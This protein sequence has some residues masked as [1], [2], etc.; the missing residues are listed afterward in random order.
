[1][2]NPPDFD[3]LAR[4]AHG[5]ATR[6]AALKVLGL[7]A[8]VGAPM[9]GAV[10]TAGAASAQTASD[11]KAVVCVY[12]NGGNDQSNTVV[13]RSGS[14]YSSYASARGGLAIPANQLIALSPQ[15]WNGPE[16]GL[17]PSLPG[18]ATLFNQGRAAVIANVGPLSQPMTLAEYRSGAKS[19]PSQLFSH[20]DQL[21]AW[22]TGLPDRASRTGW[23]GRIGDVVGPGFNGSSPVSLFMSVFNNQPIS[24]GNRATLYQLTSDGPIRVPFFGSYQGSSVVGANIRKLMT[25]ARWQ[26][27]EGAYTD[28]TQR[29]ITA[30]DAIASALAQTPAPATVFPSTGLGGQAKMVAHLI[31]AR[32]QLGH[33]RQIFFIGS[34][35]WD[36]HGDLL[37]EQPTRLKEF[38]GA[39]SALYQATVEMGVAQQVTTFSASEFGRAL[40]SN[41]RGSDHGWGGHHLVVGGGVRGGR[42]F[43]AWPTVAVGGPEDAGQ[44][45]LLPTTSI[46]EYAATLA[47]WLGV[48]TAQLSE[49]MPNLSRFARP[50]LGFMA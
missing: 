16:L 17:S 50:N 33:R 38:D 2:S 20:S 24:P 7:G 39:V 21:K 46:D 15:D 48:P 30:G 32:A 29:A 14:A 25:E 26:T 43:G 13:P 49:V 37:G 34:G 22:E 27:L 35:G 28:L 3:E 4:R 6:R 47:A 1:M 12:Q 45:R 18:V 41:G 40:Q 8:A 42:I 36:F 23:L 11:Y 19:A 5:S 44:G 9:A 10:I 31:K